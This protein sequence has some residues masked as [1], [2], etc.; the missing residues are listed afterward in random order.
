MTISTAVIR[1]GAGAL[2]AHMALSL[3]LWHPPV[4]RVFPLLPALGEACAPREHIGDAVLSKVWPIVLLAGALWPQ[5]RW[6][7]AA[8]GLGLLGLIS[9]D[10]NRLQPWTYFY[11]LTWGVL[12]FEKE[13]PA[14]TLRLLLAGVYVWGGLNKLTPYFAEENFPWFCQAFAWTKPLGQYPELGYAT[15]VGEALLGVGLLWWR[16]RPYVRY[17]AVGFHLFILLALSPLGLG[18]NAVVIPWNAAM[19]GM[20]WVCAAGP[21]NRAREAKAWWL[22]LYQSPT[23]RAILALV[24]LLPALNWA[25]LWPEALSWK[26]YSNTQPEVGFYVWSEEVLCSELRSMWS[27]HSWDYNMRLQYDDWAMDEL[28]VPMFNHPYTH[29]Q[30]ARYLCNCVKDRGEAGLWRLEVT[31]WRHG[32]EQWEETPCTGL[33]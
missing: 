2:L 7:L 1:L 5:K 8:T 31:P 4:E 17:L 32:D 19:A 20:V 16:S 10:L 12:F 25:K 23:N 24:W 33:R 26:M 13:N 18:W 30:L 27:R 15:A 9:I 21:P 6:L 3:P 29:R 11:L 14:P 28:H 22:D